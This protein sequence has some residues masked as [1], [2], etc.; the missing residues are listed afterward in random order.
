V[1]HGPVESKVV[2]GPPIREKTH[3]GLVGQLAR[4]YH[5]GGISF[6]Y[7]SVVAGLDK[8]G[9]PIGKRLEIDDAQATIVREIFVRYGAGE[10]C[11]RI[12]ADLNARGMRGPL[13]GTW[14]V[15]ALYGSPAKGSGILNNEL[16]SGRYI[17]NRSRWERDPITKRRE[18]FVRPREEWIVEERPDLRIVESASWESVRARMTAPLRAGGR[19]GRGGV[20]STLFGGILRCGFCGGAVVKVSARNYGCAA[21]KDRGQ[22]V[23]SGIEARV[24]EVE[25]VFLDYLR[26]LLNDPATL[27]RLEREAIAHE[28]AL[29]RD[30][31]T[32]ASSDR[33]RASELSAEIARLTDAIATVG[34]SPALAERLKASEAALQAIERAPARAGVTSLPAAMRARVRALADGLEAALREETPRAREALR[35]AFGEIR[36]VADGEEV[37]A[38]FEDAAE[39]LMLAVGGASMG[40]V[41]GACNLDEIRLQIR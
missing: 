36:L 14:C 28:A 13:G 39:R 20:P 16:Y 11:Q 7:R 3:R 32:S 8:N 38:E 15:S 33:R 40:R 35:A 26:A 5:A 27:A 22:A 34:I 41:A 2:S 12:A 6:G 1:L 17:W 4:G 24:V 10:S 19:R 9:D 21:A 25:R 29:A 37:V 23:C 30:A 31:G 18:R